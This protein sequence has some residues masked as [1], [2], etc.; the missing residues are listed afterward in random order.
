MHLCLANLDNAHHFFSLLASC[1][2]LY[3]P[4]AAFAL[5]WVAVSMTKRRCK[6]LTT[7]S[8]DLR[9]GRH[10]IDVLR[11]TLGPFR[12]SVVCSSPLQALRFV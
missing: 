8:F 2:V 4:K 7:A 11:S 10:V 5:I 3:N 12:L 1:A 9:Y 6:M